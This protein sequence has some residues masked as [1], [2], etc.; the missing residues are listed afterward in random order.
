MII[1]IAAFANITPSLASKLCLILLSRASLMIAEDSRPK[2]IRFSSRSTEIYD[3][4]MLPTCAL[5]TT[6]IVE[7]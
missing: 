2:I 3:I 1:S 5:S 7:S 6:N 4:K